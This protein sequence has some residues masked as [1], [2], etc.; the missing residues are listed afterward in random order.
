MNDRE[1]GRG[2]R[3]VGGNSLPRELS[4]H[5][6][7]YRDNVDCGEPQNTAT[8]PSVHKQVGRHPGECLLGRVE[9]Q[10][11]RRMPKSGATDVHHRMIF[12]SQ[13]GRWPEA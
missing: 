4:S 7:P 8:R 1:V 12:L 2:S 13:G 3:P 10:D 6:T 11:A 9:G 5:D